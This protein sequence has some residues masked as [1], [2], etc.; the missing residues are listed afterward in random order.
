MAASARPLPR[1]RVSATS[2]KTAPCTAFLKSLSPRIVF[3]SFLDSPLVRKAEA[4]P[5]APV[6]CSKALSTG[7]PASFLVTWDSLDS[8]ANTDA[9]SFTYFVPNCAKLF[10]VAS[11]A[12]PRA[13]FNVVN[14]S[15]KLCAA[16]PEL[17]ISLANRCWILAISESVRVAFPGFFARDSTTLNAS[18]PLVTSI[19]FTGLAE[20]IVFH[21]FKISLG[22]ILLLAANAPPRAVLIISVCS[23]VKA[24]SSCCIAVSFAAAAC[25]T[26]GLTNFSYTFI[27][28]GATNS[29]PVG[30]IPLAF[31][32]SIVAEAL[33]VY[34]GSFFLMVFS[35][36][37]SRLPADL[38]MRCSS[39]L[40]AAAGVYTV[41]DFSRASF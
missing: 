3:N 18:E 5:S 40:L 37:S 1:L 22:D 2:A 16:G 8:D 29:W 13:E 34:S 11:L 41:S 19:A 27:C 38:C 39:M 12:V 32:S 24:L 25:T 21:C 31:I 14:I 33:L 17:A 9:L 20:A 28:S 26:E 30:T 6:P 36:I 10:I 23:F 4:I 35:R 7:I 15:S